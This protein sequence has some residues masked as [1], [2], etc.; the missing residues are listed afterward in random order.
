MPIKTITNLPSA[1]RMGGFCAGKGRGKGIK[2]L[3]SAKK[4]KFTRK[5]AVHR[6]DIFRRRVYN[7]MQYVIVCPGTWAIPAAGSAL[8]S[9]PGPLSAR[10]N[11]VKKWHKRSLAAF[12]PTT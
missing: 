9:A 11:E 10:K 3:G 8:P 4:G 12:I 1:C 5:K 2:C 7:T 6:L